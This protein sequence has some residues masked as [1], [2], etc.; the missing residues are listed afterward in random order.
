M[1]STAMPPPGWRPSYDTCDE[2]SQWCRVE[3]T[4]LGYYPNLG[5]NAFLA[6]AY[7]LLG[8]LTLAIGIW[9]KTW[10]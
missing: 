1:S 7:G 8:L 5:V 4:T 9:K 2:V 6:A 10:G 3:Y